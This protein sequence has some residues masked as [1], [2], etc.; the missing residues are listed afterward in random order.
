MRL[1][2]R[3]CERGCGFRNFPGGT[4]HVNLHILYFE[5]LLTTHDTC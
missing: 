1:W 5:D 4:L 3:Y 2:L